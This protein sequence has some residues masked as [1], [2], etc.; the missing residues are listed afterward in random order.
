MHN[1]IFNKKIKRIHRQRAAKTILESNF[2][3]E[4][5]I[6]IVTQTLD[7]ELNIEFSDILVINDALEQLSS[8][9]EYVFKDATVIK[10]DYCPEMLSG[11]NSLICDEE[12]LPFAPESFDLITS[13]LCLHWTN[14]LP[15]MLKQI[16]QTLKDKGFF[17]AVM[18][19]GETL[20]ELRRAVMQA[21]IDHGVS[22]R[23]SPFVHV[24]DAGSLL[25]N[26]G[27]HIPVAH[28]ESVTA[29]YDNLDDLMRDLR[30]MGETN[31][32]LQRN[33]HFTSASSLERIAR[34]YGQMYGNEDGSIP[35]TFEFVT[36]SGWK[37]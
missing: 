32:L 21:D 9:V 29:L 2:L 17:M 25:Q 6:D 34:A 28:S 27:F 16:K 12:Q 36:L 1:A 8:T 37:S 26:T 19:G 5:A 24:K 11:E 31:A 20:I 35:A 22:P 30:A 3:L 13:T 33:K 15:A 18:F 14:D 10:T 7:E 23:I 4:E